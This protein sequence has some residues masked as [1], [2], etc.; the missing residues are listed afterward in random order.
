MIAGEGLAG[1]AI[2]FALAAAKKWE[3]AGWSVALKNAHFAD[4][5]FSHV[6]GV[7]AAVIGIALVLGLCV[8]LY[9]AGRASEGDGR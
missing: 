2:A 4:R 5:S 7:P 9:R 3:T 1:V 8:L 6:A